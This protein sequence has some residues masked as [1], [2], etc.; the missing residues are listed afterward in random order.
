MLIEALSYS[1]PDIAR[2]LL[3]KG[4]RVDC[5]KADLPYGY[6]P[7]HLACKRNYLDI[8]TTLISKGANVNLRDNRMRTPLHYIISDD[9]VVEELLKN[10]ADVNI[11]DIWGYIPLHLVLTSGSIDE[12]A[13]IR[14]FQLFVQYGAD[15]ISRRETLLHEL[16]EMSI[17]LELLEVGTSLKSSKTR[18]SFFSRFMNNLSI[19]SNRSITSSS[20]ARFR[21]VSPL[22]ETA[23]YTAA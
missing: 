6:L 9:V 19:R 1:Q 13:K 17:S 21:G 11:V 23:L 4:A 12:P 20:L 3:N 2:F 22:S 10:G 15:P 18:E 8:V 14:V 16:L 5:H 7:L